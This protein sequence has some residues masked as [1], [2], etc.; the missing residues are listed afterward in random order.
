MKFKILLL[1]ALFLAVVTTTFGQTTPGGTQ[2]NNTGRLTYTEPNGGTVSGQT[3]N[4]VVTVSNVNGLTIT[5]DGG[6]LPAVIVGTSGILVPFQ[7]CNSG[8]FTETITY[9][10]SGASIFTSGASSTLTRAVIDMDNSGTINAGDVDILTNGAPVAQSQAAAVCR[11]VLVELTANAA[12]T[13]N[14]RLGDATG[15]N[16]PG[17]GSAGSVTAT[18]GVNAPIEGVGDYGFTGGGIPVLNAPAILNGPNGNPAAVGPTSNNDDFQE[19]TTVTGNNVPA[20]TPTSAS[21]VVVFTNTLRNDGGLADVI[22]L[23]SPVVPSGFTIEAS[24]DCSSYSTLSGGGSLVLPSTAPNG[25]TRNYCVRVT[26]PAG[27]NAVQAYNT[28]IR[29]TSGNNAAATNDTIDR[30]WTGFIT[31]SKTATIT[32][33]TGIGG[34]NDPVPGAHINYTISYQNLSA[35]LNATGLVI[36]EDGNVAPNNW[37]ATTTQV[38][39]SALASRGSVTGDTAGSTVLTNNVGTLTAGQSGTFAFSRQIN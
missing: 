34:A 37:A 25:G 22:T 36:T 28:T 8:N 39:G 3:N 1:T 27:T 18:G 5:P 17:N 4:Y 23:T 15:D 33:S 12:G 24:A 35:T 6:S 13:I 32:N 9:G 20:G 38:V 14:V 7:V 26:A 10:A 29:A 11:N 16:T 30:L 2:I 31:S 19:M 21:A